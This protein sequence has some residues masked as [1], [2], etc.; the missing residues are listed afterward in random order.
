MDGTANAATPAPLVCQQ[1]SRWTL[2]LNMLDSAERRR[3]Y[4]RSTNSRSSLFL[5]AGIRRT[6]VHV[7]CLVQDHTVS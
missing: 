5:A 7:R 2:Y 6:F 1:E 4:R 3:E